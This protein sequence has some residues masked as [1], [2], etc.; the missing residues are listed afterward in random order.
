MNSR[1][2]FECAY[3]PKQVQLLRMGG[4]PKVS[5][6]LV[7]SYF[8]ATPPFPLCVLPLSLRLWQC[9]AIDSKGSPAL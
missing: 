9:P 3:F 7:L 6:L 2:G 5:T 1:Q 4:V 8:P